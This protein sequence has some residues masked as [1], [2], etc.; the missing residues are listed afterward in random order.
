[1]ILLIGD[2]VMRKH[3]RDMHDM[4]E[5]LGLKVE[6]V[7]PDKTLTLDAVRELVDPA[8][9][10]VFASYRESTIL[11]YALGRDKQIIFLDDSEGTA[12]VIRKMV[13]K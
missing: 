7:F 6:L 13:G 4:I 12:S 5:M 11:G 8:S 2:V 9:S 3:F 10:V 1:M